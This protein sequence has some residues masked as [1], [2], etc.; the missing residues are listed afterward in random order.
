MTTEAPLDLYIAVYG[1]EDA[2]QYD[3]DAIKAL[4]KDDVITVLGLV[5]ISRDDDE[6]AKIHIKDNGHEV[7]A[8]ATVGAVGGAVIG[9]IFPPA[10]LASAVVGGAIGAGAGGLLDHHQKKEIKADVEQDMP[11]G[12]SAIVAVFEETWI[13]EIDKALAKA[14]KV[15]KHKVD[16]KSVDE[17]TAAAT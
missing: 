14:E 13:E 12:S 15:D 11:P 9:L 6:D 16:R 3:W 5:L 17:V 2:A 4:A 8:L 1:D 10:F 7:G